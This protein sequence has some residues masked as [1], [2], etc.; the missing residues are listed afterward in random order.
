MTTEGK[1]RNFVSNIKT[2]CLKVWNLDHSADSLLWL[3]Q[4]E[5]VYLCF[6][7][8]YDAISNYSLGLI[9]KVTHKNAHFVVTNFAVEMEKVQHIIQALP[10]SSI[11]TLTLLDPKDNEKIFK[12]DNSLQDNW[13]EYFHSL[14]VI[15]DLVFL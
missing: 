10:S 9:Q 3:G 12:C 8:G 13:N 14:K 4:F 6:N 7:L 2:N 5:K 15:Y 11:R 1:Y